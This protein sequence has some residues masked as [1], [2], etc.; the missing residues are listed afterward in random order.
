MAILYCKLKIWADQLRPARR[1]CIKLFKGIEV[2]RVFHYVSSDGKEIVDRAGNTVYPTKAEVVDK[3]D[4]GTKHRLVCVNQS[5][6]IVKYGFA[7]LEVADS[8]DD[9][10]NA[11]HNA[12]RVD[13]HNNLENTDNEPDNSVDLDP[14]GKHLELGIGESVL[15]VHFGIAVV[16]YGNA[17]IHSVAAVLAKFHYNVLLKFEDK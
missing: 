12:Q 14:V 2:I 16:A 8:G 9:V 1:V 17:F 7:G 11:N 4:N 3:G 5:Y 15:C 6:A 13:A 10:Q